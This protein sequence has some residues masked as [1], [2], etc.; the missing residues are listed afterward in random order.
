MIGIIELDY[1]HADAPAGERKH[2]YDTTF[3][4]HHNGGHTFGD[5]LTDNQ[6]AA[7]LEYLKTI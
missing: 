2:I 6:R 1:G 7:V 5:Q 3:F 4:A